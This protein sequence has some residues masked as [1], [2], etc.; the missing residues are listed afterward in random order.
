[1][2]QGEQADEAD[3]LAEAG[4]DEVAT[5]RSRSGRGGR[6]PARC[7]TGHRPPCP[8]GPW[9]SWSDW[10]RA[11]RRTGRA[12][13]GRAAGR[14]RTAGRPGRRRRRTAPGRW[15]SSDA[16]L[17][18]DVEHRRRTGRR[19]AARSRG[20]SR[21]RGRRGWPA[22]ATRIGPR[23]RPRGQGEAEDLAAGERQGVAGLHEVAGEEDGQHDLGDLTG[24]EG[25][26]PEPDPDARAVDGAADA[27]HQR[28]DQQPEADDRR[29]EGVAPQHPVVAQDHEHDRG[30]RRR[31]SALQI[32]CLQRQARR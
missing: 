28:Q 25:E 26:R 1:M 13:A 3:L 10:P 21:R 9:P 17:G 2:Q 15:R 24:L 23:S 22:Q 14:G 29:G 20:P 12:T 30:D 4:D 27:G 6:G 11:C 32:S 31:A 19:T 7:R 5:R 18:G 8:S 16:P